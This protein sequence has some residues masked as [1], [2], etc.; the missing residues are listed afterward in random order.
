MQ[1]KTALDILTLRLLKIPVCSWLSR[2]FF[3][4]KIHTSGRPD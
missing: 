3:E 1:Y 2:L 4:H